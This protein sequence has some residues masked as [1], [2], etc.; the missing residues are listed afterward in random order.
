ME[1]YPSPSPG[2]EDHSFIP[3]PGRQRPQRLQ[4]LE[5][6]GAPPGSPAF[7]FSA[8]NVCRI[9][10]KGIQDHASALFTHERTRMEKEQVEAAY[11]ELQRLLAIFEAENPP[12][13]GKAWMMTSDGK[14]HLRTLIEF[15]DN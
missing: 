15:P 6:Q 13:E 1:L 4:D 8:A 11:E 14:L 5:Q 12:P 9:C 2:M 10:G 7:T 3:D